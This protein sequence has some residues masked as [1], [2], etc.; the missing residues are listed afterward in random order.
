MPGMIFLSLLATGAEKHRPPPR[1]D[2][3]SPS[4]PLQPYE[5]SQST[6]ER[7][8][9]SKAIVL[10]SCYRSPQFCGYAALSWCPI[11]VLPLC[12]KYS[13]HLEHC[14]CVLGQHCSEIGLVKQLHIIQRCVLSRLAIEKL[15]CD[16]DL[17]K[18]YTRVPA[19]IERLSRDNV[20]NCLPAKH[21]AVV[22]TAFRLHQ[23]SFRSQQC[24]HVNAVITGPRRAIAVIAPFAPE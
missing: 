14:H 19:P 3:S 17:C 10:C 18:L 15:I 9:R 6:H 12:E 21:C 22:T 2:R 23:L 16:A 4:S 13:L 1:S 7:T 24:D 8:G 5:R 20:L 11:S